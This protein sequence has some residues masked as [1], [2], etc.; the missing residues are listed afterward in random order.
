MVTASAVKRRASTPDLSALY[1]FG[2]AIALVLVAGVAWSPG[3]RPLFRFGVLNWTAVRYLSQ[4]R[5][6]SS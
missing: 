1:V 4:W 5:F 6:P 2:G 3:L